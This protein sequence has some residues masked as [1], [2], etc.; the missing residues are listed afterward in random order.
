[1]AEFKIR[2]NL[3]AE[4]VELVIDDKVVDTVGKDVLASWVAAL[5]EKN[6]TVEAPVEEKVAPLNPTTGE[7]VDKP[8]ESVV[9]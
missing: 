7:E 3:D 8:D 9:E 6:K 2:L 1:M 4:D 5:N